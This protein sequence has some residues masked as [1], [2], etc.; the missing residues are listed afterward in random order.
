MGVDR[1]EG[2]ILIGKD[3]TLKE[4]AVLKRKMRNNTARGMEHRK[5]NGEPGS[6]NNTDMEGCQEH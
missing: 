3:R 6:K 5:T 4:Q 2:T 1:K